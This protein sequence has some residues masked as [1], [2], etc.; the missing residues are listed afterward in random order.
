MTDHRHAPRH[1]TFKGGSITTPTAIVECVIRNISA[2]GAQLELKAPAL[3]PQDFD[4]IIKPENKRR[5]CRVMRRE[6]LW[7]GVQFL[8]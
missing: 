3:V 8:N 7:L 1:R 4:L 6:G 2:T 5:Q